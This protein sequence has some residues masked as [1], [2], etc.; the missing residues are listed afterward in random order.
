MNWYLVKL[1]G[2]FGKKKEYLVHAESP[3]EALDITYRFAPHD[4][5]FIGGN[6]KCAKSMKKIPS[7]KLKK[8]PYAIRYDKNGHM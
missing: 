2:Y 6:F 7:D 8:Y 4:V 5:D 1:E 3:K